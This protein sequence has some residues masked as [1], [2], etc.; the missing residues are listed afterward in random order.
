ML[1]QGKSG[2]VTAAGS[3]IGRANASAL[4]AQ[5]ANVMVSDINDE[6]GLETVRLIEEEGGVAKYTRCDVSDED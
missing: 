1:L 2:L 6:S 3:G 5:G 4:T